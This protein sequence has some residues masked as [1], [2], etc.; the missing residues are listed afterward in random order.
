MIVWAPV[1]AEI[2]AAAIPLSRVMRSEFVPTVKLL[3][4]SKMMLPTVFAPFR[5][6]VVGVAAIFPKVTTDPRLFGAAN[7]LQFPPAPS[8]VQRPSPRVPLQSELVA[9][10]MTSC[11]AEPVSLIA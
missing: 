5:V 11:R 6:T 10:P 4:L 7:S 1:F 8:E 2:A 3:A 9:V